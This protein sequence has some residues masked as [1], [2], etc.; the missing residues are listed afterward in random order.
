MTKSKPLAHNVTELLAQADLMRRRFVAAVRAAQEGGVSFIDRAAPI[1]QVLLDK[2]RLFSTRQLLLAALP[3]GGVLAEIGVDQGAFSRFII[4]TLKPSKLHL[5]DI[6]PERIDP[7]NLASAFADGLAQLHIGDSSTNL[8]RFPEGH[9]N[10]IY[11]DGDHLY[12]GVVRD[13]T[14]AESKLKPGGYMVLNDYTAW[15]PASMSK[16]GVAKAANEFINRRR[17]P[18]VAL[19][20]QG[21]GY[22]DIA[23]QKPGG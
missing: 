1:D 23:L 3:P 16:C 14:V 19:A 5:F 17:W 4:D 13:I 2:A 12:D 8:S 18:V 22:Y 6:A 20:L 9:F 11:V 15:S 21:A 7:A 10:M